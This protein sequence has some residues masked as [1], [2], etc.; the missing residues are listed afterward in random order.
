M[1][2]NDFVRRSVQIVTGGIAQS[3]T[4]YF[5]N[6]TT[7]VNDVKE[8][9]DMGR[10]MGS[11]GVKKFNELKSSGIIKKTRDWFYNEGGM[12]GDFDFDDDDFDAGFEIDS[13]DSESGSE[14][15]KPLSK[16]MMSD[17][18]KKQTGA[19]Y[20]AF[21]RQADLHIANTAE[22]IST[23]NTRTAELT[24]SVNNVNNTLIQIGKRL[25]LI[26]EWTAARTK[27]EEEEI[28]KSSILDYGGG[29]SF[30]GVVNKAKENAE[31]SMLGTFMSI[32]K[33]MLGS[34]MMTPETV[35][36]MILSQTILDKKWD[37]LGGKSVNEIGE[38]INDTV[39]E[40]VQNTMTRILTSK[41]EM[42]ETLF[43]DIISRAGGK[44]YQSSVKNT[45]NDKPAVFDG[46]TRKS[47]I[48]VIPGYL[49]E[50]L[51]AVNNGKGMQVDSKG[52]LTHKKTDAFVKQVADSYFR[53]GTMEY[54]QR[55]KASE[56]T[57]LTTQEVT[58]AVRTLTGCWMWEMYASGKVILRIGEV[59]D[60]RSESTRRV[61]ENAAKM[62]ASTDSKK[63][64]V[65]EWLSLYQGIIEEID[66]FKYRQE[67]QR[68]AERA[69]KDLESFAKT[70]VNNHQ[71][72]RVDHSVLM[73]A[74]RQNFSEFNKDA[75]FHDPANPSS[76]NPT[77]IGST[78]S[79]T[80]ISTFDYV[81][82]I[83]NQLN[84]GMN[85]FITGS[86][87]SQKTPYEPI[88]MRAGY[89]KDANNLITSP[90]A[91]V[92]E[93]VHNA[94][95]PIVNTANTLVTAA[96]GGKGKE[97]DNA[98]DEIKDILDTPEDQRTPAQVKALKKYRSGKTKDF[99]KSGFNWV[100]NKINQYSEDS[101]KMGFVADPEG[102][103][104]FSDITDN[105][106]KAV[107]NIVPQR[108]KDVF[109]SVKESDKYQD[110]TN[111][112]KAGKVKEGLSSA[113]NKAG[114]LLMGKQS[115]NE[116]GETVR[117]GGILHAVAKP[118]SKLGTGVGNLALKATPTKVL[119]NRTRTLID[120]FSSDKTFDE[121]NTDALH[122]QVISS[123][124]NVA[125]SNGD[126]STVDEQAL[127][128]EMSA[129]QDPDLKRRLKQSVI[130]LMKR[131]N[132]SADK[133]G[134]GSK[135]KPTSTIGKIFSLIKMAASFIIKPITI[136][137]KGIAG[138]IIGVVKYIGGTII[139]LAKKG[140]TRG[141]NQIKYGAKS[142]VSGMGGI[143]G[144]LTKGIGKYVNK[145][146]DG[147]MSRKEK[148]EEKKEERA[149]AK[150]EKL[151]QKQSQTED[152]SDDNVG[153]EKTS[154]M[155]RMK[156]IPG[157]LSDKKTSIIDKLT[158]N[159]NGFAAGFFKARNDRKEAEAKA[160]L[161]EQTT[162]I[163]TA[164]DEA[165]ITEIKTASE[166]VAEV[167]K[168]ESESGKGFMK[169]ILKML[170]ELISK[171]K[172]SDGASV[173]DGETD[174]K[175]VDE[176]KT[177]ND[178]DQTKT[179]KTNKGDTSKTKTDTTKQTKKQ[180]DTPV[181]TGDAPDGGGK[182]GGLKNSIGKMLGG[183]TN[184][185]GGIWNI[186][187]SAVL[188][189]E[190]VK[191]ATDLVMNILSES[192]EPLNGAIQAIVKVLKPFIKQIGSLVKQ[193]VGFIVEIAEI[194]CDIIQP[195][196]KDV[197]QP[198]LEVVSPLLQTIIG[199]LTPLL[200]IVGIILKVV[201]A[202]L[203]GLFKFVL[204]P[205]LKIIGDAVQIIMGVLQIGFGVL[206]M[207]IGGIIAG[208]GG[209]ISLVGKI[210]GLGG[211]GKMGSGI[212]DSGLDMVSQGK[213]FVVQGG[214]SVAQ[215]AV[216]LVL[217]TASLYTLGATD[218]LL[219]RNQEDEKKE[220][221]EIRPPENSNAVES[222]Y[223]N[224][225]IT[226]IYNNGS[227][228]I[229]NTYGGE[230][231][232]G[233]GGYL[234]M[235]QRGCGPIALADM[236]NRNSGGRLSARSLAGSMNHSGRYDP[237][238]GTSVGGYIDT[239]RS[240]GMNLRPGRVTQQSLKS[241]S[242]TNPITVIG[243]GSD[244]GT[245]KGN[246][247]FMNVVGTDRHGGAY[248]SN[249]LT[250]RIDRKPAST[251]VGT[252]VLGLYGSGDESDG[253]YTFPDAIKEA[254]QK[255]KEEANKILGLFSMEKSEEEE[256]E[257][258]IN[259]EQNKAA[260]EQA[261]KQL[262]E[263]EYARIEDEA[264]KAARAKY[265]ELYPK[266]DGQTD[267]DYEKG[268]KEYWDKNSTKYLSEA[269][270]YESASENNRNAWQT[271]AATNQKF[272]EDYA[273]K[274][275]EDGTIS[276]GL[277]D[278]LGKAY[279]EFDKAVDSMGGSN[280]FSSGG[281]VTSSMS[282][283]IMTEFGTPKYTD[284]NM[285]DYM[286]S[287]SQQSGHSLV[288]SF[289]GAMANDTA[290]SYNGNYYNH[291][292]DP[293]KEGEGLVASP[294]Y[295]PHWGIDINFSGGSAGKPLYAITGG[296]VTR[297]QGGA[298]PADGSNS[299][300]G[301]N[302]QWQDSGGYYHWY[303]H[304]RDD[305]MVQEGDEIKPGQ[306]IGYV[307]N[308][309]SSDGAHLHYSV[310]KQSGGSKN[311]PINPLLYW[312]MYDPNAGSNLVGDDNE[313]RIW[314]YL[315]TH[316]MQPI[317]AAG[318]MGNWAVESQNNPKALEGWY[319][320]D[321]NNVENDVVK[322][323]WSNPPESLDDYAINK[324][325][326][327]YLSYRTLNVEGYKNTDGYYYPGIGLAQWTG[328]RGKSFIDFAKE[329]GGDFGDLKTQL[330]YWD[331]EMGG[332]KNAR[333]AANSASTPAQAVDAILSKY[334]VGSL[335]EENGITKRRNAGA[336]YYNKFKDA[337]ITTWTN[338]V[339]TATQKES[340]PS[341]TIDRK[342]AVIG[343]PTSGIDARKDIYIKAY[344][345]A[346]SIPTLTSE[347]A[348][349]VFLQ[350]VKGA[351]IDEDT[352]HEDG[353]I[354]T[355]DPGFKGEMSATDWNV[356]YEDKSGSLVYA[357][358]RKNSKGWQYNSKNPLVEAYDPS[359]EGTVKVNTYLNFR[360]QPNIDAGVIQKLDNDTKLK[361]T[362]QAG[363]DWYQAVFNNQTGY[364]NKDYIGITGSGDM[365]DL[366]FWD[367]YLGW[368]NKYAN[369]NITTPGP[370]GSDIISNDSEMYYD[371]TTGATV[372]NN[373]YTVTRGEDSA[374]EER[375]RAILANTYN[376]RSESMEAL[377][378]AILEELR[379][380]KDPKG[381]GNN[382][383]GSVKL[384]DERIPSQV[385]K[386][387]IG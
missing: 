123:M 275:N 2:M 309:G 28:R 282:G 228:D 120:E 236:Y 43:E 136:F 200:K 143:F 211:V 327:W 64:S 96:T 260:T 79:P 51:K 150:A 53:S 339:S 132:K 6:A 60:I 108:L 56:H 271:L 314:A 369:S 62:M 300:C 264:K 321:P 3:T 19:M 169:P 223:A 297:S 174:N 167:L 170:K 194:V 204:L 284:L 296:K 371:E 186:V 313:Q 20:K 110:I 237:N 246:N 78:N 303:M 152:T 23:I 379:K 361:I 87:K 191:M 382:T 173:D 224:G 240:M 293:T 16:D 376:V 263:E 94:V 44:N 304:M 22:I 381:G 348:Y 97:Y 172:D 104:M 131:N 254:F 340:D 277:F 295:D 175:L 63:R 34:G 93:T 85:V 183:I 89:G 213:D 190:G 250:G 283:A 179:D 366:E 359:K 27:K 26:V 109:K 249:P 235:D 158:K 121:G 124:V 217:D 335:S 378:R 329:N 330:D 29:I 25:D 247:H 81:A 92:A 285:N 157:K 153:K 36:S 73:E 337:D 106:K 113:K 12:F 306:Q 83:F 74:F 111:S 177:E 292:K 80:T 41:N 40:V 256:T 312:D 317:G 159:E 226:N 273:G 279:T 5:D 58:N 289:F 30:S 145:L 262:G 133:S 17:I 196:M 193:I 215:G 232:R 310:N 75:K 31:D 244:Y 216:N 178:T 208:I 326:P 347:Q 227:S 239:A 350:R 280:S 245:R 98:P 118:I 257:D 107:S 265:E 318:F 357:F 33:T 135:D 66:E 373:N 253:G 18:A 49:N 32:G 57:G 8:V 352:M 105:I 334:E 129:I 77:Q 48:T 346:S 119:E 385:T 189:L 24:A 218:T 45:Y 195:I 180:T 370:N 349:N 219:D 146:Y 176:N 14:S 386:L 99:A 114:D 231:Q 197:V 1:A 84:R 102:Y 13:A 259:A 115:T 242:P 91:N 90:A 243:S 68:S 336:E 241:A 207:G 11:N 202:P 137:F 54:D 187:L 35:M 69:D 166:E 234:N 278:N 267:E 95:D 42:L 276:G 203:M 65:E 323:A 291:R 76:T 266:K 258:I 164:M 156:S 162:P 220:T 163:T 47:I 377:L 287:A 52:N 298:K 185:L 39:G 252:S 201:L 255:L 286:N 67:L 138:S 229:Y 338:F 367:S 160:K 269:K 126:V 344:Q 354:F 362:G 225:D 188:S 122:M 103:Q 125:M 342:D 290:W 37:K 238:R 140:I 50:I 320:W 4:D 151:V 117:T 375:L 384:F 161:K 7:F 383:N 144:S 343:D 82:G 155:D 268:F 261:K 212:L 341:K 209:L 15:S 380:R 70:N 214:K 248:V 345:D 387:S 184:M 21:G 333:S 328:P 181:Q 100:K 205:I 305:P 363:E 71:A 154:L 301:N 358:A 233:M 325:I 165:G 142:L 206:M 319:H 112:E 272:V 270:L 355:E 182:K 46:M 222:T 308:T 130:P 251:I 116:D 322:Q 230:Y 147:I 302:V 198:I 168:D 9:I 192:L 353:K 221:K 311:E 299:G 356:P 281:T 365:S 324:L 59:K 139:K 316:G 294:K 148:R 128:K 374:T 307:G 315:V 10:Q 61:V 372:V 101:R 332:Y 274:V 199:C 171:D 86:N 127:N 72:R 38:F 351:G 331:K 55:K 134:D 88:K 210:P 149:R 368:N 364:V 288:H 360:D 141:I